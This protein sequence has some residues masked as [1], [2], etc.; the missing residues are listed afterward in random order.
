MNA[1]V[2]GTLRVHST[3][4]QTQC[5]ERNLT[6]PD[7]DFNLL[8]LALQGPDFLQGSGKAG[9][10]GIGVQ[11]VDKVT[12]VEVLESNELELMDNSRCVEAQIVVVIV[13]RSIMR[14]RMGRE[15]RASP[16][17]RRSLEMQNEVLL[18]LQ[19]SGICILVDNSYWH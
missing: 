17:R 5:S 1:D 16:T 6:T 12:K 4:I 2:S 7:K 3:V 14:L 18:V 19:K 15:R 9:C 8:V 11:W 13:K 10:H